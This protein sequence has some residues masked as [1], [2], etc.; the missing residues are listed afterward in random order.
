MELD[1]LQNCGRAT[2]CRVEKHPRRW[3]RPQRTTPHQTGRH[4]NGLPKSAIGESQSHSNGPADGVPWP[5]PS[6]GT[7]YLLSTGG[8]MVRR[9]PLQALRLLE[10]NRSNGLRTVME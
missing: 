2:E 7:A 3:E 10:Q 1:D 6:Y 4:V 8:S 5:A 9:P